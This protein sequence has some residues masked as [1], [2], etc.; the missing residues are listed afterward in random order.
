MMPRFFAAALV[1]LPAL[2]A[3]ADVDRMME[4]GQW[5]AARAAVEA[6]AMSFGRTVEGGPLRARALFLQSRVSLAFRRTDDA[7]K[8]AER[9][10]A[11]EPKNGAYRYQVAEVC[12]YTAQRAGKLKAFSFARRFRKEA[13]AALALDSTMIDARWALMEFY[14]IAPGIV[15]GNDK[16]A[17]VMADEIRRLDAARGH[18]AHAQLAM[19]AKDEA[20]AFGLY[21]R[22]AEADPR[23]Y[24]AQVSLARFYSFDSQKRWDLVE[25]HARMAREL[26]PGRSGAYSLLAGLYAH[27][28]RWSE[29][30]AAL[31]EAERQ[32]PGNFT[33]HYQAARILL[34]DGRELPRAERYLRRYLVAEPEGG[35]TPSHAQARWR[36]AHVLEKQG[37]KTE[38]MTEL[39][40]SLELDPD[41][42]EAKKDLKRLRRG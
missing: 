39:E 28:E 2:A 15:G 40:A 32:V 38:A 20:K 14:S 11:L 34:E 7:L 31:T 30:D 10:A 36:L 8:Q 13:E 24:S 5:K 6:L 1:A 29:L 25:K 41:L 19:R 3:A 16:K 23:N 26:D 42:D 9:A 17:K 22:A 37:R 27:Q 35:A 18:L 33:P 12:G 4:R 21:Q